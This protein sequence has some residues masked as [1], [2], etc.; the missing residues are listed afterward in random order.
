MDEEEEANEQNESSSPWQ[1]QPVTEEMGDQVQQ[2]TL[3]QKW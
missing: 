3:G 1:N 2:E